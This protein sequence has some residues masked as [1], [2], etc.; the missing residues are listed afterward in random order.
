MNILQSFQLTMPLIG[1]KEFAPPLPRPE[2]K[3]S[4]PLL[5]KLNQKILLRKLKMLDWI[6]AI[7]S[8]FHFIPI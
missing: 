2:F 5:I 8:K 1:F 4:P 7:R 6:N 3:L